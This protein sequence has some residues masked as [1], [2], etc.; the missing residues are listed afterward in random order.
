MLSVQPATM[1]FSTSFILL[2]VR[3][4]ST[5][6][7]LDQPASRFY[8]ISLA[9]G[10]SASLLWVVGSRVWRQPISKF[11]AAVAENDHAVS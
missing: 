7:I 1:F 9:L 11:S 2:F 4:F 6:K 3:K 8:I 5:A 10:V